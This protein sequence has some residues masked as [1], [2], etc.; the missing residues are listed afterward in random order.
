MQFGSVWFIG[1]KKKK[2]IWCGYGGG[3]QTISR[4]GFRV[5]VPQSR[6]LWNLVTMWP[7]NKLTAWR[8]SILFTHFK[9]WL[10]LLIALVVA[11]FLA[12]PQLCPGIYVL[13]FV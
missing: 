5:P 9:Y 4:L 11:I 2:L 7:T 10:P 8:T 1:E 3:S 6:R 13:V 12:W